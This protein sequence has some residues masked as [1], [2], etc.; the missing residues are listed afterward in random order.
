MHFDNACSDLLSTT[1]SYY[2]KV[3]TTSKQA[4]L[5][6]AQTGEAGSDFNLRILL[7]EIIACL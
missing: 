5:L 6:Q 1:E 3:L 4:D 2:V 7:K